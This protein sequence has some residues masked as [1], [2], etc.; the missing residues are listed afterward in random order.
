MDILDWI[1]KEIE[2]AREIYESDVSD[3]MKLTSRMKIVTLKKT[4]RQLRKLHGWDLGPPPS[5][6]E[7]GSQWELEFGFDEKLIIDS[8]ELRADGLSIGVPDWRES[9]VRHRRI[10]PAPGEVR[11]GPAMSVKLKYTAEEIRDLAEDHRTSAALVRSR[12]EHLVG[13]LPQKSLFAIEVEAIEHDGAVAALE[14][15]LEETPDEST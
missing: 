15:L 6:P 3:S 11:R 7:H 10:M 1:N 14:S 8:E 13:T 4:A 12:V 5:D 2:S 9:V